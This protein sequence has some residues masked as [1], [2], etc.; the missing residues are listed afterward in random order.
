VALLMA[1]PLLL[2][3]DD[4]ET[5]AAIKRLLAREG[6]ELVIAT[7]AADAIIAFGAHLPQLVMVSPGVESGRGHVVL[8]E[9]VQHPDGKLAKVLLLGESVPGFGFPVA[10][11]PPDASF[12]EQIEELLTAPGDTWQVR[13]PEKT[14]KREEP[15]EMIGSAPEPEPPTPEDTD[16]WRA[17]PPPKVESK[18]PEPP[19]EPTAPTP[20]LREKELE[21][22][23]FGDLPS[24]EDQMHKQVEAEAM[25]SVE[26]TL[27]AMPV[28][29]E[30][31][32]LEN[33]VRAEAARR[34]KQ[35]ELKGTPPPP[36]APPAAEAAAPEP[37]LELQ[38]PAVDFGAPPEEE[39]LPPEPVLGPPDTEDIPLPKPTVPT[40]E[41]EP[42]PAAS[43]EEPPLT[44]PD[45]TPPPMPP[46]FAS[47]APTEQVDLDALD[48]RREQAARR[49]AELEAKVAELTER[50]EKARADW[51]AREAAAQ[52][53]MASAERALEASRREAKEKEKSA[54]SESERLHHQAEH[55]EAEAQKEHAE[56]VRLEDERK[57]LEQR[58]EAQADEAQVQVQQA[59]E[60]LRQAEAH[61]DE[62][63][64]ELAVLSREHQ[65]LM[66]ERDRLQ[67]DLKDRSETAALLELELDEAR[68][69]SEAELKKRAEAAAAL[70]L[71]LAEQREKADA[72]LQ[73]RSE[74]AAELEMKLLEQDETSGRAI[75]E[76][77][78]ANEQVLRELEHE[79][80]SRATAEAHQA[81]L[82]HD[83]ARLEEKLD[84]AKAELKAKSEQLEVQLDETRK[85][86]ET[87]RE[88][89]SLALAQRK[90]EV[91]SEHTRADKAEAR[92]KELEDRLILPLATPGRP[93]LGVPRTG[94][95]SLS[96]LARLVAQLT[97][98]QAE[99]RL[100]LGVNGGTRSL[101]LKRGQLVAAES[102]LPYE[103][104]SD[105]AR[106][107]GLIDAR[108]EAELR[109]VRGASPTELLDVMK[110][111]N[112][113]RDSEVPG[114]V[115]RYTEAVALDAFTEGASSYR[116][117]Q[118][119]VGAE[120]LAA[121]ATRPVLPM[122][123]EA[124]RRVMP[125]ETQL[126]ALGGSEAV[127]LVAETDLDA[128]SLGFTER[129]R[130]MLS[131]VDG[132]AT[133]EDVV[134]AAGL[135]PDKAYKVLAVAKALGL[136]EVRAPAARRPQPSA[137]V[138]VQRLEAKYE[139]VQDA[140]YFTILGLPRNAGTDE[141]QR[142]YERLSE[143]FDPLRFSGHPDPSLQQ[144][145]QV[146]HRLLEE[147]A[148]A[149]EDD[150][151]RAE[152][153]RHLLD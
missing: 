64:S 130:R 110:S 142:A 105:R 9:L 51:A 52:T 92:A 126:E 55:A 56:R 150:R 17:A 133:V 132:E 116:L 91:E 41:L 96:E 131:F 90:V 27:Q 123:A 31:E 7:S 1:G 47:E 8:E 147:A 12:A 94:N 75:A 104:L 145:A 4:E 28:D 103:T 20:T 125:A 23:L 153:A 29:P 84:A 40:H 139:Q 78:A 89:A 36:I 3:A 127:P 68:T 141:V 148:R 16:G 60:A 80:G 79:R 121:T 114:L 151:R 66:A 136:I 108:Q 33:E 85:Q 43:P 86:L 122:V 106:R 69:K 88:A 107:D 65:D 44:L 82:L 137:E 61:A 38:T 120:V 77:K 101:W 97:L 37:E 93:A 109:G 63:K 25:A 129:E 71:T 70:E 115:Q 113:I 100:E 74:A 134:L 128:R 72:E 117:H 49:A 32:K 146:V 76:A 42:E 54:S 140:D 45:V 58:L 95:L 22:A 14:V 144:R 24:L 5:I 87:E 67:A 46:S 10:P 30:L 83:I 81:E 2:V 53:A 98:A 99:V 48:A 124:L 102:N 15:I 112:L 119:P 35:R 13:E 6:Y 19:P 26:S 62:A 39:P 149:L 135:R 18:E 152:Y 111:R 59:S 21:G 118:E 50:A 34:R 11:L 143:E 138:D 73:K 57:A